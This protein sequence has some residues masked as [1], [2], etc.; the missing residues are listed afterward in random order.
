MYIVNQKQ[1]ESAVSEILRY[2]KIGIDTEFVRT[3]SYFPLL[4]LI[5]LSLPNNSI[6]IFDIHAK[7]DWCALVEILTN[8]TITK[9][10]HS[11][12]QDIEAI[13][14]KFN[15]I[16]FNVVDLQVM[17]KIIGKGHQIAYSELVMQYHKI[18]LSKDKQF[19]QWGK[20]PLSSDQL[21]YAYNDVKYLLPL[22]NTIVSSLL[23][24]NKNAIVQLRRECEQLTNKANYEI[25]LRAQWKKFK[26][27]Y[28]NRKYNDL[29]K[30]LFYFREKIAI[31][32]NLIPK[33][34]MDD[35]TLFKMAYDCSTLSNGEELKNRYKLPHMVNS[36]KLYDIIK[37]QTSDKLFI[38]DA[39]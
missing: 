25:D 30:T 12:R 33:L 17:A 8:N 23:S 1:L 21:T 7:L 26:N 36:N 18:R 32:A 31:N 28:K 34:I 11:C 37:N 38:K 4:S 9:V 6:Y 16:P 24:H 19:S 39:Q 35:E 5:Q 2:D 10:I 3:R 13:K 14:H 29:L 27:K 20:R 22:Y 15:V